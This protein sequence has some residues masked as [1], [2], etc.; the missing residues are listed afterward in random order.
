MGFEEASEA[1][2]RLA[3]REER[4]AAI[5][6][7]P[8]SNRGVELLAGVRSRHLGTRRILLVE[9]GGWH[10][11][12][13]RQAMVL[14]QVD[15]YLFMP[16]FPLEQCRIR[17]RGA[18]TLSERGTGRRTTMATAALFVMI[19]AAPPTQWLSETLARDDRGYLL[20]G[21]DPP[22]DQRSLSRPPLYL[23]TSMPGVFAVGD[24]AHG[25]SRR[26]APSVGSGAVASQL[27][28]GYLD[29]LSATDSG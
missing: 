3:D 19:G 24:V 25:A 8:M 28:H 2:D 12:P 7:E 5:I 1:L 16:W 18:V 17:G 22:D 23:E 15:G 21:T 27:I 14:G 13:V 4:V 20:T 9:R 6:A 11:H 29:G 10:H 26:V